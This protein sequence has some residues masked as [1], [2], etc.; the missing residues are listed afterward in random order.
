MPSLIHLKDSGIVIDAFDNDIHEELR[1]AI[2]TGMGL[3]QLWVAFDND[4]QKGLLHAI[5]ATI[6][7]IKK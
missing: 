6:H 3:Q 7:N 4:F 5:K 2:H 1:H